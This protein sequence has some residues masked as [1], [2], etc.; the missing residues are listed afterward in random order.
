MNKPHNPPPTHKERTS[1]FL[2]LV[3][4]AQVLRQ[5]QKQLYESPEN[6]ENTSPAK[7]PGPK[8]ASRPAN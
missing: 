7:L 2:N 5:G 6:S 8:L 3:A 4:Q 1:R